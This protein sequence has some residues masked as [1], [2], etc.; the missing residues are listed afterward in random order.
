M[1]EQ[2]IERE[3]ER[4]VCLLTGDRKSNELHEAQ[5]I[6]KRFANEVQTNHERTANAFQPRYTRIT[7]VMRV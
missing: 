6:R 5:A 7:I 4:A 3:R 2:T 1:K